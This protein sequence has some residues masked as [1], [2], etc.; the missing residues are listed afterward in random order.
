MRRHFHRERVGLNREA[1][2][3][4]RVHSRNHYPKFVGKTPHD[5]RRT[6]CHEMELAG[7]SRAIAME[8]SG[9][10]TDSQFKRYSDLFDSQQ[11]IERQIA[12]QARRREFMETVAQSDKNSDKM[13]GG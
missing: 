7:V 8:V 5:F 4:G 13:S 6:A 12:A 1:E 2:A 10:R 3:H 11:K 9:H